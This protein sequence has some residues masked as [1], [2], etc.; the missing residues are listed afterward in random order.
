MLDN[1]S[2][3][4]N[5]PN[6]AIFPVNENLFFE[7][8]MEPLYAKSGLTEYIHDLIGPRAGNFSGV[9]R[10]D[11]DDCL[12]IHKE[13][14]YTLVNNKP[15]FSGIE[16]KLTEYFTDAELHG[17]KVKDSISHNGSSCIREYIFNNIHSIIETTKHVTKVNFRVIGWNCFDGSTK[18]TIVYGNIDSFC[19]NG[20][21]SGQYEATSRKRTS[22]F[23]LEDF[24]QRMDS[25]LDQYSVEMKKL[26]EYAES[27]INLNCV[28][29][30]F[31]T[32]NVSER[33]KE[34][35]QQQYITEMATRGQNLW[36]VVSTLTNYASHTNG[37]FPVRDTG[38]SHEGVTLMTR[39]AQVG[40]WLKSSGWAKLEAQSANLVS[41]SV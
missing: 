16:E 26:Q 28:T 38:N 36:A 9:F 39:Q 3:V 13:G 19:T 18:A 35:L 17:V 20:L 25:G 32:L 27:L 4:V 29:E 14:S 21:I 30:F 8:R 33:N 5:S 31:I 7:T 10:N 11:T 34:R 41:R 15:F 6:G 22:G 12:G 24:V 23:F 2:T 1:I 40:R 37:L